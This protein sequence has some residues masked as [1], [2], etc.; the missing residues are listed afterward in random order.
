[1]GGHGVRWRGGGGAV[2][3]QSLPWWIGQEKV[4]G[5]LVGPG[6]KGSKNKKNPCIVLEDSEQENKI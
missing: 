5:I 2:C 4:I 6:G 3:R 1:M